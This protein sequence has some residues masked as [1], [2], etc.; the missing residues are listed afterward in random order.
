[1][2]KYAKVIKTSASRTLLRNSFDHINLEKN[3]MTNY[4]GKPLGLGVA[5]PDRSNKSQYQI[6]KKIEPRHKSQTCKGDTFFF[7][8]YW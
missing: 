8:R 4:L 7:L 3:G 1:M 2:R 5:F 6:A